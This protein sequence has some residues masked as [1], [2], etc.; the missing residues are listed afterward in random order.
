MSIRLNRR[1]RYQFQI[2]GP[3]ATD[4]G[5]WA[6]T[7]A[8]PILGEPSVEFENEF[9]DTDLLQNHLGNTSRLLGW[10]LARATLTTYLRASGTAGTA[11]PWGGLLRACGFAETV[12]AATM[13]EYTPVSD[14]FASIT[15]RYTRD[16]GFYTSRGA[17]GTGRLMFM[18]GEI[19]RMEFTALG[20]DN[21]LTEANWLASDFTAWRSP[22][23]INNRNADAVTIGATY[24]GASGAISG[25]TVYPMRGLEIDIG[26]EL[27]HQQLIPGETVIIADRRV[28]ARMTVNLTAAQEVTFRTNTLANTTQSLAYTSGSTAGDRLTVFMPSCQFGDPRPV[29]YNGQML[30]EIEVFVLPTGDNGNNE[31]RIVSR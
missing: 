19:P 3:Y 27:T 14:T 20:F 4:P 1:Q 11:P 22:N 5:S 15:Q 25:G 31:L 8:V 21:A 18:A 7:Q 2:E 13:V 6:A 10:R 29:N 16:G 17:R 24:T 30:F 23:V 12:T 26:N 28:S 9:V